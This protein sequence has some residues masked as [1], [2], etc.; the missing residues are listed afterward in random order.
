MSVFNM[1]FL[2]DFYTCPCWLW[3]LVRQIQPEWSHLITLRAATLTSHLCKWSH[4]E[5][6]CRSSLPPVGLAGGCMSLETSRHFQPP[7]VFAVM[8]IKTSVLNNKLFLW[9]Q[10][11]HYARALIDMNSYFTT[12]NENVHF[13]AGSSIPLSFTIILWQIRKRH[14]RSCQFSCQWKQLH[15]EKISHNYSNKR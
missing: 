7:F 13:M 1:I 6:H 14:N 8:E 12:F 3:S 5:V 4:S 10:K 2:L 11:V 15:V 9:I